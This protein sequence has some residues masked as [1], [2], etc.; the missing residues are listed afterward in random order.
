MV[1]SLIYWKEQ[2]V[3]DELSIEGNNRLCD[4]I[5]WREQMCS[6]WVHWKEQPAY[7]ELSIGGDN[8]SVV[9]ALEIERNNLSL[10]S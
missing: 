3:H 10:M 2:P 8:V 1:S 7:G 5:I 4:E 9:S 6:W